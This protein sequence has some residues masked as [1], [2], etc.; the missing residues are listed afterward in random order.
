MRYLIVIF[1]TLITFLITGCSSAKLTQEYKGPDSLYFQAN[2]VL[3]VGISPRKEIRRAYEKKMVESLE[4]KGII[5]VKSIDFFET[6]FTDN[7]K[8]LEQLST[9][10]LQLLDAGFDAI[11]LSKVMGK[12]SRIS[13]FDSFR[14]LSR[15]YSAFKDYY[16][17][18][19]KFYF[20]EIKE[21][22]QVYVTETSLFC[23]CPGKEREL[24]WQGDIE[25]VD[26]Y[27]I[28]GMVKRYTKSLFKALTSNNILI[29][30]E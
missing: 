7:K 11:L 20:E 21:S 28:D 1:L 25:I 12:E 13:N 6:S 15:E 26:T 4:K 19:Q 2:K 9:V 3:V 8:S 22:Y 16:Y 29:L 24:I 27:A 17:D 14:N 5:A 23:I 30:K 18:N 10:E